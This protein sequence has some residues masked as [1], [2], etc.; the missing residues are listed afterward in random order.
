MCEYVIGAAR[1]RP[2]H[3]PYTKPFDDIPASD[4]AR[5]RRLMNPDTKTS[6]LFVC[7][8]IIYFR[9]VHQWVRWFGYKAGYKFK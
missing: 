9:L 2:R 8:G 5:A 7:M 1:A 6:I 4:A 3:L